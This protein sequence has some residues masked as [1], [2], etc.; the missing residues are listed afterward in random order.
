MNL[1]RPGQHV[2]VRR[3]AWRAPLQARGGKQKA[4]RL[5]NSAEWAL[6]CLSALSPS[7]DS[8]P[9]YMRQLQVQVA[10][11][12]SRILTLLVR[13]CESSPGWFGSILAG[14][15]VSQPTNKAAAR[16]VLRRVALLSS[17]RGLVSERTEETKL[18]Q[19]GNMHPPRASSIAQ[20]LGVKK[21]RSS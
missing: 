8:G 7:H 1:I 11:V 15:Q 14:A 16:L 20:E 17:P 2:N 6:A 18:R 19:I 13:E 12:K 9:I 21:S 4:R 10:S 5:Q 3:F